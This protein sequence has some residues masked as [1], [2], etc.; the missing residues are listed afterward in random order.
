MEQK[1]RYE[2]FKSL[3]IVPGR[4]VNLSQLRDSHC[5][6]S[7]FLK[8]K[9]LSL[10][11]TLCGL[12]LFEEAV[13]LFYVNLC[14][15]SDRGELETLILGNRLIINEL[16]FED[17]FGTKFFGVIPYMNDSWLEDFEVT[18]EG[19]KTT[20]AKPGAQLSEFGP[21]SLCFEHRILAHI[22]ATTLLPRKG[23]MSNI[24]NRDVFVLYCLLKKYR[25]NWTNWFKEFMWEKAEEFNP[26]AS[27]PYGLLISRILVD[28]LIDLSM[29]KHIEISATYDSHTFFS[30]GYVEV[31]NRWVKKDS[32]Q[33]R[34]DAA[35]PT[36]IFA[37]SAALF[38]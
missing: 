18:L 20:V 19:V 2:S 25:I 23:S 35:K 37:E 4:V 24:S 3:P 36:K 8:P 22:I 33:E 11:F 12:E 32:V 26:S 17:V 5:P 7:P 31:G 30:M 6:V 13:H 15:S 9:K 34:A 16:L 14:V 1:N 10:L 21:L 27:L 29:F 38:L 28:R